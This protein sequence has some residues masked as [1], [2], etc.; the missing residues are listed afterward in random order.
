M[1]NAVPHQTSNVPQ[2]I[3][4]IFISFSLQCAKKFVVLESNYLLNVKP[5]RSALFG[6]YCR[7]DARDYLVSKC[8]PYANEQVCCDGVVPFLR[9]R[10][11]AIL[12]YV[13]SQFW[14]R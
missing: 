2:R 14:A 9:H 13:Y 12:H 1:S 8:K 4:S 5:L 3:E 6:L 11:N 7:F 10:Q